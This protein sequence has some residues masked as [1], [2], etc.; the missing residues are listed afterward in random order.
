MRLVSP[1]VQHSAS[2]LDAMHPV[3]G[4]VVGAVNLQHSPW[5]TMHPR[6]SVKVMQEHSGKYEKQGR[7]RLRFIECPLWTT[8]RVKQGLATLG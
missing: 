5:C 7:K 6:Q 8:Q 4:A 2:C 3:L 1:N